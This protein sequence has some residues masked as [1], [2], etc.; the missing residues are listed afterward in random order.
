[1]TH[2][3]ILIYEICF[4]MALCSKN[5]DIAY[6]CSK[7]NSPKNY[8]KRVELNNSSERS[9]FYASSMGE[10]VEERY[11]PII[12]SFEPVQ[13]GNRISAEDVL[14]YTRYFYNLQ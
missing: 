3:N 5:D 14:K 1:M 2:T 4:L 11:N 7:T 13:N 12:G 6:T 10:F 9:L 8:F